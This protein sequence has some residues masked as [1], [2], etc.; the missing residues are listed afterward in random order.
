MEEKARKRAIGIVRKGAPEPWAVRV[1][2]EARRH[3]ESLL[4]RSRRSAGKANGM[5]KRI[6]IIEDNEHNLYLMT[7]ILQK[8]GYEV[9]SARDGRQGIALAGQVKPALILLDIQL[10]I[11]NG[12]DVARELRENPA[13]ADVPIVAETS[14]AM[15][16]D[17]E[18]IMAAGCTGYIEKPFQP[19]TFAAEIERYLSHRVKEEVVQVVDMI[20][21]LVVDDNKQ[22][23][24]MLKVLLEVHGYK[25]T[26]AANGVEALKTARRKIRRT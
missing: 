16:G 24:Y 3:R 7:I 4:Q 26:S 20:T 17:R 13:L 1:E 12:Y 18:R 15:A 14:Y 23:Q 21:V 9:V 19:D 22:D 2:S 5:K 10:P 11:M 25:V 6:L 8:K